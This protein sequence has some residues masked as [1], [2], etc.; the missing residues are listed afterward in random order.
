MAVF[1]VIIKSGMV[2]DG[3]GEKPQEMDIAI[4]KNE[5]VSKRK[6]YPTFYCFQL[7]YVYDYSN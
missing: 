7:T 6:S 1:D 2:F 5:I 4:N 3:T